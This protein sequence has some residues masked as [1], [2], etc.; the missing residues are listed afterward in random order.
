MKNKANK[1]KV[2][3]HDDYASL[4]AGD[5]CFYYGYEETYCK[6][7]GTD[8]DVCHEKDCYKYENCFVVTD[9]S[10]MIK[11]VMRIPTSKL[12]SSISL[13][14]CDEF[15]G[16]LLAGIGIWVKENASKNKN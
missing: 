13:N 9:Y 5:L 2:D 7:H 6:K 14:Y 12:N 16:Y 10:K 11:E 15:A 1:L 8:V 4:E 3:I